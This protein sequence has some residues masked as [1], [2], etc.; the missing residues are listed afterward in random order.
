VYFGAKRLLKEFSAKKDEK[1]C[2][3]NRKWINEKDFM[4][5]IVF[6]YTITVC[7]SLLWLP[8]EKPKLV[9]Y[10]TINRKL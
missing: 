10:F 6:R 8:E 4:T 9:L 5:D 7:Q 1:L 3:M 2:R